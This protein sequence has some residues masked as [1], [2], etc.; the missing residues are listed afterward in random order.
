V[1]DELGRV[2]ATDTL[3]PSKAVPQHPHD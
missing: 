2:Q 1:E 3:I